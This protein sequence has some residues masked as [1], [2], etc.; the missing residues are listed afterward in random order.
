LHV[1]LGRDYTLYARVDGVVHF[2]RG[3]GGH[4]YIR[5]EPA[6]AKAV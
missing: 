4:R 3:R 6:A 1:G 2:T 5:V